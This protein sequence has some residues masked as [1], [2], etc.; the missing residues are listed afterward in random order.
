[1]T[2]VK[3]KNLIKNQNKISWS[4][5]ILPFLFWAFYKSSLYLG[6]SKLNINESASNLSSSFGIFSPLFPF[7]LKC[8]FFFLPVFALVIFELTRVDFKDSSIGR[9]SRSKGFKYADIYYYFMHLLGV[10]FPVIISI[11]T[12][13]IAFSYQ[14]ISNWLNSLIEPLLGG[15]TSQF[16]LSIYL[17]IAI[18]L[19]DFKSYAVHYICHKNP[20]FWDLH[21]F[22]HSPTEMTILSQQRDNH[23]IGAFLNPLFLPIMVLAPLLVNLS[24]SKGY[25]IPVVIYTI[26]LFIVLLGSLFGHSSVKLIFPKFLSYI[27]MSPA[28][29]WIHHSINPEHYDKNL[30]MKFPFWDKMFGTYLDESHLK[31]IK[32]YGVENTEYNR[33]NPFYTYYLL[34]WKK[35]F[36]RIRNSLPA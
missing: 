10:Q 33:Y 26:D 21:E 5:L 31:D 7:F 14:G 32:G 22:H 27:Y 23:L 8:F 34:P 16:A 20:F 15:N 36:R 1:M 17:I 3:R 2:Q 29:H 9:I 24:L 30:G 6:D 25:I 13:N 11:V 4:L 18:L 28:L 19:Q 12:L 35:I